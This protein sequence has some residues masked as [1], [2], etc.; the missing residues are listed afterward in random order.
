MIAR[1]MSAVPMGVG[2][3]PVV[4]EADVGQGL[5]GTTMVGLPDLAV[6]ESRDRVKSAIQACGFPFPKRRILVN[7]APADLRKAGPSF[8]LPIALAILLASGVI[9][10]EASEAADRLTPPD[11]SRYLVIGE[12]SLT[13]E[14]RAVR[15]AL[16]VAT[17]ARS[18]GTRGVWVPWGNAREA[19]LVSGI[20]VWPVTTLADAFG[21]LSGATP[22]P[23]L[24]AA[25]RGGLEEANTEAETGDFSDVK[26]QEVAKRA[27]LIAAAGGHNVL[28][29]GP[30]GSGKTLLASR[31]PG[32]LP[33]LTDEEALET[34][35]IHGLRR[36][37][38]EGLRRRPPFRSPHHS[39]SYVSIVGGGRDLLPGEVSLA[40][41]GVLFLDE[42]PEFP[43]RVLEMLRQPLEEGWIT[44]GRSAACVRFPASAQ[45]VAAMNPCPCGHAGDGSGRCSCAPR[46]IDEYRARLSGPLLDRID[47]TIEVARPARGAF[48]DTRASESTASLAA[49][50]RAAR[51]RQRHRASTSASCA[52]P[53]WNAHV[54]GSWLRGTGVLDRDA[55][56]ALEEAAQ[57][58]YLS[59]R[60]ME[61]TLRVA[62]TISDLAGNDRIA[63]AHVAEALQYRAL[64]RRSGSRDW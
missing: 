58:F 27:L 24:A 31:L 47:L 38:G 13:G 49:I 56:L 63:L 23:D 3:A 53:R 52:R 41:N 55:A 18:L 48:L 4:I 62:R 34:T 19:A 20:E 37:A 64:D 42:L 54:P 5:P 1:V 32:I 57:R 9:P 28:L 29:F 44:I 7:L 15:G 2:V 17:G 14:V 22:R 35:A 16:A 50:V 6:R 43:R 60:A 11:L 46:R 39:S 61:R 25:I 21:W 10:Q 12:L 40:H 26:G 8:D 59:P 45:L 36:S 33:D 51:E 30:P